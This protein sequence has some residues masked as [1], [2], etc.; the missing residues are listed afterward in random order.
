MEFR[1]EKC[2]DKGAYSAKPVKPV[3]LNLNAVKS[4]FKV[5]A[6]TPILLVI[7]ADGF[8]IVAHS[9]GELMFKNP[10]DMDRMRKAAEEIYKAGM[11]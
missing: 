9:H 5:I 4:K 8:E 6:D 1:L 3:K 7:E 10:G 2:K 11:R